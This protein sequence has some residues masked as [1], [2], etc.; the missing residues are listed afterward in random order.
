MYELLDFF[1]QMID[2][3][4]NIMNIPMDFYGVKITLWQ[5]FMFVLVGSILFYY[6]TSAFDRD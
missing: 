2:F 3:A 5:V 6:I 1:R 4:F